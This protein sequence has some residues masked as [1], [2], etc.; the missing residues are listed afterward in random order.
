[1]AVESGAVVE[2]EEV[3]DDLL[4]DFHRRVEVMGMCRRLER[5]CMQEAEGTL[6]LDLTKMLRAFHDELQEIE[7]QSSVQIFVRNKSSEG[8]DGPAHTRHRHRNGV[9]REG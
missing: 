8:A 9:Q 1:M 5:V 6:A 4:G 7:L 2:T 3:E